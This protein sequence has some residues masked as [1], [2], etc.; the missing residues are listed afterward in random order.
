MAD[1]HGICH[2]VAVRPDGYTL[3]ATP[4]HALHGTPLWQLAMQAGLA[5]RVVGW[6]T[7]WPA[8]LPAGAPAGSG[9][10]A[11][12]FQHP[13]HGD[14]TC[15]PLAPTAVAPAAWRDTV[16]DARV[17]PDNLTDSAVQGLLGPVW[18]VAG[19]CLPWRPRCWACCN[20]PCRRP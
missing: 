18:A 13:G 12:G 8:S 20:C 10:V 1:V 6:P 9:L 3:H 2:D 7:L 11:A 16:H 15:W 5:A 4:A 17:Y 14:A 19:G